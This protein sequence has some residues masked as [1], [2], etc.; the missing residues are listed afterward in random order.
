MRVV[1]D[2]LAIQGENS[3]SIVSEHLL[4]GWEGIDHDDEL[5][6]VLRSDATIAVPPSVS[7]HRVELGRSV[8]AGRL[9]AQSFRLPRLCRSVRA[10]VMLGMLPSTAPTPLPC[11]HA[12][13]AWDFRY[14]LL[15]R[16]FRPKTLLLRRASYG[17]GFR[18][19]DAVACISERTRRDLVRF[20]PG[21]SRLPVQVA[22]LG[23]DHVESWPARRDGE[24]YAIAFGH[25]ANKNLDLVL[26]A[27]FALDVQ[28]E[29]P[30]PLR[31]VGV[32][33]R[34]RPRLQARVEELGLGD[35]V[36][37]SPWLADE[38]FRR[39]FAS[40]R[41][42]V[43]PSDFEGFGLPAVEAMRLGI[44]VVITPEPAL[45]EVTGGRATVVDGEGPDA[46]ARAV[47]QALRVPAGELAAARQ[48][49][50]RFTWANFA[51]GVRG[52][53]SDAVEGDSYGL[54]HD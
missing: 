2:G 16:Q 48:D 26:D 41:L 36:T 51:I 10:D 30:L 53:L 28:G 7:V 8:F 49:A 38:D 21:L 42:V 37:V 33:E 14:R 31:L 9:R 25:L 27:W 13:I 22:H 52:L 35:F 44:P 34:D 46:L 1:I 5:H 39:T 11:P 18:Q 12:V 17:I 4:A 45:L 19:T 3:L 47:D 6:L 20:H 32:C 43:F 50:N 54:P 29:P 24:P 15:P 23:A 40:A